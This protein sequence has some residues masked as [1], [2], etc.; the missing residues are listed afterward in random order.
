M[1]TASQQVD[2]CIAA[3]AQAGPVIANQVSNANPFASPSPAAA[4]VPCATFVTRS[5]WGVPALLFG[6]SPGL[7]TAD[8]STY[9]DA[10]LCCGGVLDFTWTVRGFRILTSVSASAFRPDSSGGCLTPRPAT[11]CRPPFLAIRL[12]LGSVPVS[13]ERLAVEQSLLDMRG[14]PRAAV[15]TAASARHLAAGA[16]GVP[17][18]LRLEPGR[19][20]AAAAPRHGQW[21]R[22]PQLRRPR[23]GA[24]RVAW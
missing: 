23:H 18:D 2:G 17:G 20:A 15:C 24:S 13:W 21:H 4:P 16:A 9:S 14:V 3:R 5:P 11:V 6:E 8:N 10:T 7:L 22:G 1:L 19:R 12:C